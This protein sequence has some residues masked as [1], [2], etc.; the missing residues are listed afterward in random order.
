V[1]WD[2]NVWAHPHKFGLEAVGD[3]EWGEPCYSFD[4][5]I[6]RRDK[7]GQMYYADDSGCSCPSPFEDFDSIASL[8]GCTVAELQQHL[9]ERVETSYLNDGEKDQA[10]MDIANLMA[11][12][13]S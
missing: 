10:R 3:I 1:S 8:T 6:V 4:T 13:T 9:E 2:C 5:T 11:R 12:V 7:D